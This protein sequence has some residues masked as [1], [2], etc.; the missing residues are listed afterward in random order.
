MWLVRGDAGVQLQFTVYRNGSPLNLT[1]LTGTMRLT[2]PTGV[3]QS[4][5]VLVAVNLANGIVG[6]TPTSG[7]FNE[8]GAW[9]LQLTFTDGAAITFRTK[10]TTINVEPQL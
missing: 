1:G 7:I 6:Y 5:L 4:G 8:D 10:K 9:Q 3:V 2:S